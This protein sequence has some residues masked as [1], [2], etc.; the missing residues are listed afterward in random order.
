MSATNRGAKRHPNDFYATPESAFKPLMEY[1]P[2][3]AEFT[4]PACGDGRLVFWLAVSGRSAS[5]SDLYRPPEWYGSAEGLCSDLPFDYLKDDLMRDFVI[6]NPPFSLAKE[7]VAHGVKHSKELMLLL[8]L[9]FL[10][11]EKRRLFWLDH[12]PNALFILSS[13][14][15][16]GKN[17]HGKKGTD[18]TDY[19]WF[20]WGR[21]YQG[22]YWL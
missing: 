13:R 7:F 4:D 8:R 2:R 22:L 12:K 1:L 18:A 11:A 10:A 17:K 3:D 21:R 19:A 9:N 14:P 16:F 20:Y 5:G 6:T 15:S